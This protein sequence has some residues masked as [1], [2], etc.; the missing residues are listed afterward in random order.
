MGTNILELTEVI[1]GQLEMIKS[2]QVIYFARFLLIVWVK[3]VR[4][5]FKTYMSFTT[6]YNVTESQVG[7][8]TI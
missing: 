8:V 4:S 1:L 6:N 5:I 3:V 2:I 7:L